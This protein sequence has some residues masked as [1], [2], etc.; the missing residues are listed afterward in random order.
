M[1]SPYANSTVK[2]LGVAR[3]HTPPNAPGNFWRPRPPLHAQ[4]KRLAVSQ[5]LASSDAP[6]AS[7]S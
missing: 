1:R 2:S 3:L 7:R 4:I 6:G 5:V